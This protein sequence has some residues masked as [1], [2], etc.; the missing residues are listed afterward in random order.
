MTKILSSIEI[1]IGSFKIKVDDMVFVDISLVGK[2]P[3]INSYLNFLLPS[4]GVGIRAEFT[5]LMMANELESKGI[6]INDKIKKLIQSG[7]FNLPLDV[8]LKR[9][10]SQ[11]VIIKGR[12]ARSRSPMILIRNGFPED[13]ILVPTEITFHIA[14]LI[15]HFITKEFLNTHNMDRVFIMSNPLEKNDGYD[16]DRIVEWDPTYH[17]SIG[18]CL[19]ENPYSGDQNVGYL[20]FCSYICREQLMLI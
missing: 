3:M 12:T 9:I 5:T 2:R 13:F 11:I 4:G 20:F 10:F 15:S 16:D 19:Y 1:D 8:F 18:T 7:F 6:K 17:N 14:Y